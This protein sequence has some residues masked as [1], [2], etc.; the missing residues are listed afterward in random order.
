MNWKLRALGAAA[1]WERRF[2]LSAA[3][4][5]LV[6]ALAK[7]ASILGKAEILQTIDPII[8]IPFRYLL[9]LAGLLEALVAAICL[10]SV[11]LRLASGLIAWLATN[12]VVYRTGLWLIGWHQPCKCLGA[13]TDFLP[14]SP[15]AADFIMK[16]V[17]TFLFVGSYTVVF[18]LG[19]RTRTPEP[20]VAASPHSLCGR[21]MLAGFL[22]FGALQAQRPSYAND[23]ELKG[24][25][26]STAIHF[27]RTS[28]EPVKVQKTAIQFELAVEDC[29]WLIRYRSSAND[30][31][32]VTEIYSDGTNIFNLSRGATGKI[33]SGPEQG[34]FGSMGTVY[35][36]PVPRGNGNLQPIWLAYCSHC[37][38]NDWSTNFPDFF[39]AA[40]FQEASAEATVDTDEFGLI[41]HVK[42]VP[43]SGG[44][45]G[46]QD[47]QTL[48]S[49]NE[50]GVRFILRFES[51]VYTKPL[52]F[53]QGQA[54]APMKFE[55][56]LSEVTVHTTNTLKPPEIG[57]DALLSDA[58]I[59]GPALPV[60]YKSTNWLTTNA[61]YAKPYV[62]TNIDQLRH[63]RDQRSTVATA[64]PVRARV[65]VLSV[66]IAGT[67]LPLLFFS[68]SCIRASHARRNNQHIDQNQPTEIQNED[69]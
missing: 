4:L 48:E 26:V 66:L 62:R 13:L 6:T 33:L 31:K 18:L 64:S 36:G 8:G 7:L 54:R 43:K 55:C 15:Q 60:Q 39:A 20:R 22:T 50:N 17:L 25:S 21:V 27:A 1:K 58:R 61:L 32:T 2:I 44:P 57:E 51:T 35:E 37:S 9:L 52:P 42:I 30:F 41:H 29:R 23:F 16:A 24:E 67:F 11:N 59:L 47:F 10:F 65:I 69:E 53:T 40:R 5:L 28:N 38:R 45:Y 19:R 56:R 46:Y 14:I 68:V 3:V 12:F 49:T 34:D 63:V